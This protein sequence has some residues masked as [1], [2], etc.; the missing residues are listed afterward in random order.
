[1]KSYTGKK[2]I[3]DLTTKESKVEE[4][5]QDILKK[6]LGG[7][8]LGAKLFFDAQPP[9]TQPFSPENHVVIASGPITGSLVPGGSKFVLITKSPV[10]EGF[11]E[12]YS[13]GNIAY[14][15]KGA[16]YDALVIK[17]KCDRPSYLKIDNQKVE[18]IE[19]ESL[20]GTD[21]FEAERKLREKLSDLF[22]AMVIGPAGE[23]QVLMA[24]LNSDFYRQ[25]ARG[26]GGTIFG[27]KN[28]KAVVVKGTQHDITCSDVEKVFTL[29]RQH[30]EKMA[31][32]PI[33]KTR[34]KYGSPYTLS[35]TNA[36]GM[37]PTKNFTT[38]H[39][40]N[41]EELFGHLGVDRIKVKDKSCIGCIEAC[42]KVTKVTEGP[43]KGLVFEGP[44]Y[45]TLALFGSNLLIEDIG[46][47]VKANEMCDRLGLDTIST[48]VTIGF[49]M[50]CY[51]KGLIDQ[52]DTGGLEIKF[53]DIEVTHKLIEMIAKKEGFGAL[54]SMGSKRA[55]QK[56]GK[57]SE[58]FAMQVKGLEIPAYEPR[59][60]FGGA[61]AYAVS[62]RG[63][64]HR[65]CWPVSN[66]VIAGTPYNP[67]GK[68][69]LVKKVWDETS[70]YHTLL[71][72]DFQIK[73]AKLSLQDLCDYYEALVGVNITAEDLLEVADRQETLIRYF[74]CQEGLSKKDDTLPDRCF[75]EKIPS[76]PSKGISIGKDIFN[77]MLEEYYELRGWNNEGIP[78]EETLK[79]LE[80]F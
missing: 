8:G 26:G 77:D 20:W 73:H 43:H 19:D 62:P 6:Y 56:I 27:S 49:A 23:N 30:R 1:M 42:S 17:G 63:A 7:R 67:E 53:G 55:A 14:S 5:S 46:A 69:K 54:L 13:S 24:G 35:M 80:V 32:N 28:L 47:I 58:K 33:G 31:N 12:S 41:A 3:V 45:E 16:G 39:Y 9:N 11:L 40:E 38:G 60:S 22:S 65:R 64:C 37:L 21:T 34:R 57:G 44:E 15:L 48:A 71:F 52:E 78:T 79:R 4:I 2:L 50:E 59:A 29:Q 76:G 75:N 61:L 74:N 51:E 66:E 68:A 18:I 72:C 70:I 36:I 10:N 25:A